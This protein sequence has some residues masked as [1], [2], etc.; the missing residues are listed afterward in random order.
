MKNV[1]I[2]LTVLIFFSTTIKAEATAPA[3]SNNQEF[4]KILKEIESTA[5]YHKDLN[6]AEDKAFY[7]YDTALK[8]FQTSNNSSSKLE[9]EI[10][11]QDKKNLAEISYVIAV[12]KALR[13]DNGNNLNFKLAKEFAKQA[14]QLDPKNNN[15]KDLILHINNLARLKEK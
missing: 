5:F 14:Q 1:F 11:L 3:Y 15:I 13:D 8:R 10:K 6:E 4:Q 2:V 9:S 7:V 12:I